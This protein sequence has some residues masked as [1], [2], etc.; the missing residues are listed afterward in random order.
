MRVPALQ[1]LLLYAKSLDT[2][3]DCTRILCD[4]WL[5]IKFLDPELAQKL[6]SAVLYLRSSIDKLFKIRLDD[7]LKPYDVGDS[8]GKN[9]DTVPSPSPITS[10]TASEGTSRERARRL[11]KILKNKLSEFL[12]SSILYSIRRVLPAEL[13]SIYVK[14]FGSEAKEKEEVSQDLEILKH[15][16][17][18]KLEPNEAKGGYR[19]TEYLTY[20]W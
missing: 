9:D 20:N 13:T 6:L 7:R 3:R 2:N 4:S 17:P 10:Q 1:T 15:T 18:S 12:D 19:I 5:E 11:E 8:D 16:E 14:N